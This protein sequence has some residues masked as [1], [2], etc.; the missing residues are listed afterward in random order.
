MSAAPTLSEQIAEIDR[1]V[2]VRKI[3]YP[4]HIRNRLLT[5]AEA[6]TRLA[7]MEAVLETL[8]R[9]QAQEAKAAA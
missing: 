7:R 6:D 3:A 8:R 5:Q 2:S 4:R 9:V 1:E